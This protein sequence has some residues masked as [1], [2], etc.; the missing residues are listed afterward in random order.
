M[1]ERTLLLV[2]DSMLIRQLVRKTVSEAGIFSNILEAEDGEKALGIFLKNKIDFIITDVMLP[3]VNGYELIAAV[4]ESAAGKDIPIIVISA[5]RKEVIDKIRG[6]NM[7]ASDYVIKPFDS[8]ELLARITVFIRLQDLQNE[9]REKNALLEKMSMTDELTGLYN[10][11]YFYDHINMQIALANRHSYTIGC[12]LIDI[13]YFKNINDTCGHDVGDKVLKG[14]ANVMNG[15]MRG[16]DVLARFGGEEFIVCLIK[17]SQDGAVNAAERMRKAV[18]YANLSNDAGNPL[19]V[20]ISIGVAIYPQQGLGSSDDI[21]KA[22]DN[23]LYCA[24]NGGRN[25]TA[26]YSGLAAWP[27]NNLCKDKKECI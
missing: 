19:K 12:L 20:T 22:A 17:T 26:V 8:K 1:A 10:R 14:A 2:D 3:K 21:I 5:S 7:G 11:R 24:K 6:L 15:K 13:D 23:A 27:K 9:L 18:G 16:G 25:R 4:K